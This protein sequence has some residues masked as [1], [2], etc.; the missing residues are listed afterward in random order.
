MTFVSFVKQAFF[1]LLFHR[2]NVNI[3]KVQ[4]VYRKVG[5]QVETGI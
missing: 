2:N 3:I 4:S 5:K 1:I